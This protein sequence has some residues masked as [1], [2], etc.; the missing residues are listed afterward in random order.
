MVKLGVHREE[1]EIESLLL[2]RLDLVPAADT[3]ITA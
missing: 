2:L 1:G 3:G